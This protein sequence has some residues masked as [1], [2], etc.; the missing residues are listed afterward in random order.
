M[1]RKAKHRAESFDADRVAEFLASRDGL[2]HLRVRHRADLVTIES[3]PA[4]DPILHARLRRVTVH[5]WQLEMP[6]HTGRWQPT[7]IRALM[8]E[9]L[10]TLVD[11]FPWT[12]TPLD[13]NP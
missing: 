3:G 11:A 2:A 6:T 1:A 12:L 9:V 13:D 8:D 10:E 4:T 7:P 5:L